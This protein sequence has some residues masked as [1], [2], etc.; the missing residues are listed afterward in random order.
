MK[1]NHC[2]NLI[3]FVFCLLVLASCSNEVSSDGECYKGPNGICY[4][5]NSKKPF[6]G[7]YTSYYENGQLERRGNL[8]NGKE[9]GVW[10]FFRE[11]GLMDHTWTYQEGVFHGV[12]EEFHKTGELQTR[13][14]WIKG[15]KTGSYQEFYENGQLERLSL[16]HI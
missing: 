8:K 6:T 5:P 10:E 11:N 12:Y 2:L 9:E 16:I 4:E 15:R 1:L 3:I 7:T 13:S 14:N